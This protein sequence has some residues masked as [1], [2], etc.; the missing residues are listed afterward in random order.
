MSGGIG[1]GEGTEARLEPGAIGRA[2][3]AGEGTEG[4]VKEEGRRKKRGG[5]LIHQRA[6]IVRKT[7]PL[8]MLRARTNTA[9]DKKLAEFQKCHQSK[10]W[11]KTSRPQGR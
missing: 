2:E 1:K 3:D 4:S 10:R 7:G 9:G 8:K 5:I 6:V 11:S